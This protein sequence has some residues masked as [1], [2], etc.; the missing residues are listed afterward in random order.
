MT[1]CFGRDI[2]G[3]R[4][5]VT[6]R[7]WLI[8]NGIGGYGCGTLAGVLTRRYHGLLVAALNPPLD[9]TLLVSQVNET[10][11]YLGCSYDLHT[12]HWADGS[13]QPLGY[14]HLE[15]FRLEGTIPIW[16]YALGDARLE[17]R[18]W[19]E[20]GANTT[21]VRYT[22]TRASEPLTLTVKV[23]L[24]Y[25]N[26]HDQTAAN[27]WQMD[28]C[29]WHQ[30]LKITPNAEARPFYLFSEMGPLQPAHTWYRGYHLAL[31]AD[32][33]LNAQED[34]LHGATATRPLGQGQSFTLV[35]TT[36]ADA[37]PTGQT[38][39]L[40][41]LAYEQRLLDLWP[42]P[43]PMNPATPWPRQLVLAADQFIVNRTVKGTPGK[44][45]IAGYP[46]FGDWGRDTM[47]ALPGLTLATGRAA[48]ARPILYTFAQYLDQGMLPN[49]FPE[50]G[51]T[52]HYNTVDATLWY[53]EAL[54]AYLQ[55][56]DDLGLI[57]QLFPALQQVITWHH[58]GSRHHIH[59]DPV[60][61]LLYAGEP[62]VQLTWM[63]AK[64]DD[65][66][67]TPRIG[68]PIEVNAL[69]YNALLVMQ[70]FARRL[71]QPHS[72]YQDLV[73]QTRQGL[74]RFW[75]PDLGYCYD[76]LDGPDGH[77]ITLRPN[78][79]FAVTLPD[80]TLGPAALPLEQQKAV[81]DMV[82]Q[83]L[84][85][86]HGVRSLDPAHPDY[87]GHYGGDPR[88]R[89]GAYHQ[90]TAWS[91]L[92]GAFAQAHWRVY[93]DADLAHSFLEPLIQHLQGGCVGT[94]SEIFDG[95]APH[96]PRGAFAQAW[97]VAE[98]LRV[99]AKLGPLLRG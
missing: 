8:T 76:L 4:A 64:V 20:P 57:E 52:P 99:S 39:L 23:L 67:V 62:G 65:W 71:G 74:Q 34:H 82:A 27:G 30:G 55:A 97:S 7:E 5:A 61:G 42:Q 69:W 33:G 91:W 77:D 21:Y 44:T 13:L 72:L 22:V 37:D 47:I 10:V 2:C 29:P 68:K 84:V 11:T 1:L 95:D 45:I 54:R 59:L 35:A 40:R 81:V 46:W 94:L 53:F 70:Q 75:N 15:S 24:N 28:I 9:R 83:V 36:E 51:Q 96:A 19:M 56:T 85:T 63:D 80:P 88:Q 79:I 66:V 93:Q 89:D 38:A 25:R 73:E 49:V 78:Q 58:K 3:D 12:N 60:D 26:H 16:V 6:Q 50:A 32:R 17:K 92:L 41:R 43:A 14:Y 86:S 87:Q 98:V 90:G 18:L 31:E 48:V